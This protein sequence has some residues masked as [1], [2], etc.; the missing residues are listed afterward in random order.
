MKRAVRAA[1][2]SRSSDTSSEY[3][4]PVRVPASTRTP[5]P[6]LTFRVAFLTTPSSSEAVWFTRNSK[7]HSAWSA[8]RSRAVPSTCSRARSE[9]PKRSRKNRP[10]S[11]TSMYATLPERR[12]RGHSACAPRE[13]VWHGGECREEVDVLVCKVSTELAATPYVI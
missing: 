3:A 5:T 7:K 2:S 12:L 10:G 8:R 6:W 1:T 9:S 13:V 11:A 4:Y